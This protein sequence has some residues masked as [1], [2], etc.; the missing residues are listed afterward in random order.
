ML[1]FLFAYISCLLNT[2]N[3]QGF[4]NR[5]F[6]LAILT[7]SLLILPAASMAPSAQSAAAAAGN[8]QPALNW[9]VCA[10]VSALVLGLGLG[11]GLG[12][13]IFRHGDQTSS[14]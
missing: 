14:F 6:I 4:P 13:L 10:G 8:R 12:A 3:F 11:I 9:A 1:S 2:C 7:S 5:V